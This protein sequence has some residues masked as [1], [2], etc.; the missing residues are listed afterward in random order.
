ME[1][2]GKDELETTSCPTTSNLDGA[3]HPQEVDTVPTEPHS[4]PAQHL[5]KQKEAIW[6]Q[7]QVS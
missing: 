5:E 6:W 7:Q 3:G 2:Q 4:P 1:G